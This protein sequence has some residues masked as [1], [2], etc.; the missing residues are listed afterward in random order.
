MTTI[1]ITIE[2]FHPAY[3][4][5]G[6]VQSIANLVDQYRQ[7]GVQFKIFC[8][9]T[10]LD[11]T[12]NEGVQFDA[13]N[14]Y[15]NYT[16]VWYTSPAKRSV[17]V[18]LREIKQC[19][20][21]VLFAIGIYSG[22]YNLVP[23]LF[24]KVPVKIMSV[25]G[26]VHPGALSQKAFKKKIY[27]SLIKLIGLQKRCS[28]HATDTTEQHFIQQ[29]F[30]IGVNTFV[31]GNYPRLF[32]LQT[33]SDKQAGILQLVTIALVSPMKNIALVL[34][35]LKD[36]SQHINYHI[37]GPIKDEVYWQLCQEKITVLPKHIKVTYHG[38]VVPTKVEASLQ[39]MKVFI[40][41]SK[42]ENFGHAIIEALSAG[43][44]VI[45]SHY[46]PFN[47]LHNEMA[48]SNVSIDNTHELTAAIDF[49][50]AMP[51]SE[52]A[53]WNKGANDYALKRVDINLLNEQYDVMFGRHQL[54]QENN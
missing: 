13:W 38:N 19:N 50:A 27:L 10:D 36:C 15:N 17:S 6:P 11:D 5:G 25:R 34:D 29:T 42:S 39:L 52:F 20:A 2:W 18:M 9:S 33:A 51:A 43:K 14:N 23:L 44:P 16:Q 32:K 21:S 48:G 35:A 40:M 54:P 41:P 46:T 4:A 24:S 30:G 53:A 47:N 8:S 7:E 1:F 12:V 28:F 45:T 31:A 3:K 22:Y 49:F 26:M 37:Y